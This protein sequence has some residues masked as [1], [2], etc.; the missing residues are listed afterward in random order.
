MKKIS[1]KWYYFSFFVLNLINSYILMSGV[2]HPNLSN[3]RFEFSSFLT[4]LIGNTGILLAIFSLSF[5]FFKRPKGRS[6]FLLSFS[7]VFTF[8]CFGLAIYTNIFSTFFKFSQLDCF[9][10]PTTGNYILFYISYAL[11]LSTDITQLIHLIPFILLIIIFIITDKSVIRY[12]YPAIKIGLLMTSLLFIVIPFFTLNASIQGTIYESSTNNLYGA[13]TAG[14]YDYYV[15]DFY[16]YLFPKEKVIQSYEISEIED[17][18][19]YYEEDSYTNPINGETYTIANDTTGLAVGKN[20]LI[21]Q[22]EAIDDFAVGLELNGQIVMPTLTTLANIGLHYDEFYSTS[23]IGNTSDCEFSA[24]T[25]LIG[26]G[27]DLTIFR[28]A[29]ERY[30][31][32]PKDFKVNGYDTF[33]LHGNTGDFYYRKYEHLRTLGFDRHYDLEY[34]QTLDQNLPLIHSYL[35][36]K[37]F[38]NQLPSILENKAP[39]FGYAISLTSHSPYVPS[40]KIPTYD[41]GNL[42]DLASSYMNYCRYLDEALAIFINKMEEKGLLDDVV[43][44]F[45]GDHTSSLF[46]P[47]YD[48]LFQTPSTDLSFRK[49]LQNV[50]LIIYNESLFSGAVHHKVCGTSDLYRTLSNL[51][52]LTSKYHFGV[53]ILSDE[54]GYIYSPRNLDIWYDNGSACYPSQSYTGDSSLYETII[55]TFETYKYHNDLI[56]RTKY[57]A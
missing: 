56:L 18:L 48:S 3:Y 27:N 23:G 30:E 17:F 4:S 42:T 21:I 8:I 46:K 57:F 15:Y 13:H 16:H 33:S 40:P 47:D 41:W 43:L 24:L 52:G 54:P 45:Y 38:F 32:L 44:V 34:F 2:V 31:T 5:I 49:N 51:F 28:Y 11:K 22:L 55:S 25:G 12:H 1:I 10:N 6:I 9:N 29:G 37:Y 36:D 14:V 20:L 19:S 50:P 26:N 7:F 53:D 35:D 39:Y